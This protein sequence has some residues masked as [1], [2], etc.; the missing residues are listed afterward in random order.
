MSWLVRPSSPTG[1]NR[2]IELAGMDLLIIARIDNV[3]VYPSDIDVERLKDA[4]DRALS[5][6]PLV[7]GRFLLLDND[8]YVIE[9]SDNAIP[10]T[11]IENTDLSKWSINLNIVVEIIQNPLDPFSDYVQVEK[12]VRGSLDEPL[13]R[14]KL[15]RLVQSGECVMGASWA[16]V[17]GDATACLNFLN[18]VSRFYQHME[19]LV[20][21]PVFERRLWREDEADRSLLTIMKSLSD[22]GPTGQAL[23]N[24]MTAQ[25]TH[26]QINLCFSGEQLTKLR[27][28]AGGN[29]VTIQD[30]LSAYIIL[31]LNTHCYQ[32]NEQRRILR[33]NTTI[34]Y[35]GV[36]DSIASSSLIANVVIMM[37]SDDFDDPLSL[38]NIAKTIRR[39]IVRSRDPKFLVS[40]LATAD[41]LMKEMARENRLMNMGPFPNEIAV[42][43]NLR[44]DWA[45]AVD[46][47]YTD[48]CRLYT[49]WTG[50]LYL[51]VF[52]LN[53]VYD[54]TQW[55]PRDQDGAEVA[56]RIEKDM[57]EQFI[58]AW[59]KDIAEN[60]ANVNQ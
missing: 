29:S 35:R 54:G 26:D 14:L 51:R 4:L 5:L 22:A 55:M 1:N 38:S 60:F 31:I 50:A 44:Y 3:F 57:K 56:F 6:W 9:M 19:P 30:A 27:A 15:T 16:H 47:G 24:F 33:I 46:F 53:P 43:S 2:H 37:L 20:P 8:H 32:N 45:N 49:A 10:V 12:M 23:K 18:T 13:F 41:G 17:L 11:L 48:K 21:L 36:S 34:N 7:A 28:L 42:N 39:S 59:E 58:N 40:W 25:L 52:R